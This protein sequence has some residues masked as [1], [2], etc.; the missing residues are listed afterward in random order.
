MR[1]IL[2]YVAIIWETYYA[3]YILSIESVQKQFLIFCS[4]QDL[5]GWNSYELP[6]YRS[7][8]VLNKLLKVVVP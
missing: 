7:R 8:L 1:P 3:V 5:V 4:N 2:E 6:R